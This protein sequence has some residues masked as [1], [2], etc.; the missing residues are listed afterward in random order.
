MAADVLL[1]QDQPTCLKEGGFWCEQVWNIT[2]NE[3]FAD[4]ASWLIAKPVTIIVILVVALIIRYLLKK[5]I[6]RLTTLPASDSGKMPALLKPLKEKAPEG[7]G[8]QL[9]E[10]RRQRAKTIGSV[11]NSFMSLIVMGIAVLVALS[12]I[13]INL[14]PFIASAGVIG[15]A[16]G[17]GAQAVVKDFLSGVFMMIE[18]Q[19]GVGDWADLGLASGTVEAVGLR[20]TTLR[21]INGTVWY[22]RNGEV[23]RV[24]NYNQDFAYAVVDI[25]LGYRAD[26]DHATSLL[27][28][29][30]TEVISEQP[31]SKSVL[32][33]A[34][35]LGVQSV[36]VEG[37]TVRMM[38]KTLPGSQW[39]VERALR[40]KI[41]PAL[42]DAGLDQ[43]LANLLP[44]NGS[45]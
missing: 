10:R 1:T 2:G 22:V 42:E 8:A 12:E 25:P 13:G 11:L 24:G 34:D 16:L 21:D 31:I 4:S 40:A 9:Q 18:D 41:M 33:P 32:G 17:F 29:V 28:Q 3:W 45:A 20:V 37:I 30:A 35:V 43:P 15:V 14:A 7:M 19:Y 39:S 26:V 44:T 5:L 6:I 38:V 23:L 36:S 27:R